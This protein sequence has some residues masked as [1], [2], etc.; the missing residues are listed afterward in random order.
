VT[1]QR[2]TN[3]NKALIDIRLHLGIAMPLV[4]VR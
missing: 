4:E 2:I 3:I 1:Y